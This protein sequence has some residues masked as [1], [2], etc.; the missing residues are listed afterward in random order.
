[1]AGSVRTT[2]Y[3]WHGGLAASEFATY[4]RHYLSS[5]EKHDEIIIFSDGCTYQNRNAVLANPLQQFASSTDNVVQHKYLVR[6]HS[7][8]DVGNSH[9]LI[10]RE[11][12]GRSINVPYDYVQLMKSAG[13]SPCPFTVHY[14]THDFFMDFSEVCPYTSIRPGKKTGDPTVTDVYYYKYTPEDNNGR[15]PIQYEMRF[16]EE[17]QDISVPGGFASKKVGEPKQ[18]YQERLE[19]PKTKYNP[20]QALKAVIG[21]E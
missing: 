21:K 6:G 10:E 15:K 19:I 12:K 2:L 7:H 18:L 16:S 14:V 8:M 17:W 1:M 3:R 20:L 11:K 5:L 13:K 4:I 9:S